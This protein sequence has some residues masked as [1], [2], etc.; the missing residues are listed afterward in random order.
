M[1]SESKLGDLC[2]H[3]RDILQNIVIFREVWSFSCLTTNH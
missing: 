2:E 3:F 1:F